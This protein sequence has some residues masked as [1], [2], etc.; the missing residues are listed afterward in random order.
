MR[1]SNK[2]TQL[3]WFICS[4]AFSES[5]T[6]VIS[7]LFQPDLSQHWR[8]ERQVNSYSFLENRHAVEEAKAICVPQKAFIWLDIPVSTRP[9]AGRISFVL[10]KS[11]ERSLGLAVF[12][13][14]VLR[15]TNPNSCDQLPCG[16]ESPPLMLKSVQGT[17]LHEKLIT[18]LLLAQWVLSQNLI[19]GSSLGG[20]RSLEAR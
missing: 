12:S 8:L 16:I 18:C 20:G 1:S 9:F 7:S 19:W 4:L 15:W 10:R 11:C 13:T 2:S 17:K 5:R 3:A 14:V 6:Y